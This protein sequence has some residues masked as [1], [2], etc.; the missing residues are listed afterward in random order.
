MAAPMRNGPY[1]FLKPI[2]YSNPNPYSKPNPSLIP[3]FDKKCLKRNRLEVYGKR[4]ICEFQD[5][6]GTN[7]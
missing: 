6:T 5:I 7:G 2:P 4:A 1:L 3:N